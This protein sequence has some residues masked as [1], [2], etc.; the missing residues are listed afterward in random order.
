MRRPTAVR[1]FKPRGTPRI[2]GEL[3]CDPKDADRTSAR[4]PEHPAYVIYTSGSSG[5]PKGAQNEHRAIVNRST[6]M[7]DAYGLNTDDVVLQKT[8]FGFDVSVWEFFWTLLNGATM[9]LAAPEGHKNAEYLIQLIISQQ[10]T[11]AQDRKSVV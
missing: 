1:D 11:T 3:Q 8:P 5:T 9:V 10:V 7:Q 4:L 2:A 6:W